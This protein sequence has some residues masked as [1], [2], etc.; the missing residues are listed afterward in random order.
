VRDYYKC[1]CEGCPAKKF[2]DAVQG[3]RGEGLVKPSSLAANTSSLDHVTLRQVSFQ[4]EHHHPEVPPPTPAE[5]A[6]TNKPVWTTNTS[7]MLQEAL[8]AQA[9]FQSLSQKAPLYLPSCGEGPQNTSLLPLPAGS[10][11]FGLPGMNQFLMPLGEHPLWE[12]PLSRP[13]EDSIDDES[14]SLLLAVSAGMRST[15]ELE[16]ARPRAVASLHQAKISRRGRSSSPESEP[17]STNSDSGSDATK[18]KAPDSSGYSRRVSVLPLL[19]RYGADKLF[20]VS[21]AKREKS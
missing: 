14:A 12:Q 17:S 19:D 15:I 13:V 6:D 1:T 5:L 10:T 20:S 9:L 11:L 8:Q 18:R 2:V 21:Q 7:F 3:Q 16:E 4:C